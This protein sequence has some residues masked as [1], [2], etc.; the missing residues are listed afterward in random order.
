MQHDITAHP[1]RNAPAT[2]RNRK[3]GTIN[4]YVL[5]F[6]MLVI[7]AAATWIV[8]PGEFDHVLREG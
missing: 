4:P 1:A 6:I 5:L 8:P 2:Q 7:T 3:T